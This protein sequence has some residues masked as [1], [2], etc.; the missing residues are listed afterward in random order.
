MN[1]IYAQD[2][3]DF[4]CFIYMYTRLCSWK[5][6]AYGLEFY[7]TCNSI[8]VFG[9]VRLSNS[10]ANQGTPNGGVWFIQQ[11]QLTFVLQN[12]FSGS[13]GFR[14]GLCTLGVTAIFGTFIT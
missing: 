9:N 1:V 13:N 4:S 5:H 3:Y 14:C 11:S 10:Q 6:L 2:G 7:C 12:A 8:T